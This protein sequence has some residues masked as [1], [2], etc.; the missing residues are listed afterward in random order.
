M[1][2]KVKT[3]PHAYYAH[4][5]VY[6]G[7]IFLELPTLAV[8]LI[9]ALV[10]QIGA[11]EHRPKIPTSLTYVICILIVYSANASGFPDFVIRRGNTHLTGSLHCLES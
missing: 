10:C 5:P 8:S 4:V 7:S 6:T 2:V 1:V 11:P 9:R 3:H